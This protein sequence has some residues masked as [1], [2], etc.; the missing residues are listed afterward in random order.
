MTRDAQWMAEALTLARASLTISSPNPAVGAILVGE[1]G[2]ILGKGNT[3]AVGGPHAEAMALRDAAAQGN[4]VR[5]ATAYVTL[6]PCSHQG[7]TGPCCDALISAGISTVVASLEDPNPLVAGKGFAKLRA[8][9]VQVNVGEQADAARELYLG[10]FSRM[11]RKRPW[12]RLKVAA[13]LDGI[14]ALANGQSQWITGDAA[15]ADGHAWRAQSCAVLT[16]VGTVLSDNPRLDVRAIDTPRQPKRVV[17]DSQLQTPPNAA[18]FDRKDSAVWIYGLADAPA[19][20]CAA[21]QHA[22]AVVTLLPPTDGPQPAHKLDLHAV[23]RDLA[24]RE[25]NE[26]HVEAGFKLNGSLLA[27]GLVDELLL[28]QAPTLLGTGMGVANVSLSQL[29]DRHNFRVHNV[30]QV[31]PDLRIVARAS[32]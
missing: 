3:Q 15:R 19:E 32:H 21:L 24:Q 9:G 8:A 16:G 25:I 22:G 1:N 10:F 5:G 7:R 23:M 28:Y 29:A 31:G 2:Q 6:E 4:P 27:A 17:I 30:T 18:L 20:R 13:S 26:V 12:L 14:T 11:Q